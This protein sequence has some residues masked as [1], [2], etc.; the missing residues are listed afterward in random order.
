MAEEMG[1]VQPA[2]NGLASAS[3]VAEPTD[4][5]RARRMAEYRRKE[6]PKYVRA[7]DRHIAH[8]YGPEYVRRWAA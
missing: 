5:E 1:G 2:S 8:V 6:H 4:I 3:T 7:L